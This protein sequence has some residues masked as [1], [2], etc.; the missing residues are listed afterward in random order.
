MQYKV[1]EADAWQKRMEMMGKKLPERIELLN[2]QEVLK[3][4]GLKVSA[5]S[6]V[7]LFYSLTFTS[8]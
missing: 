1:V 7:V 8:I 6:P 2:E 4:A 5:Y 3:L